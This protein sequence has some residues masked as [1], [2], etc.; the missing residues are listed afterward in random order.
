MNY[1]L[2]NIL[3]TKSLDNDSR[4][5]QFLFSNSIN[6]GGQWNMLVNIIQKYGLLPKSVYKETHHSESTTEMNS[7]RKVI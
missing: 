3:K 5:V 6:D 4:M 7:T 2:E 1:A